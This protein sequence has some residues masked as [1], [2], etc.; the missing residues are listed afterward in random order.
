MKSE[1]SVQEQIRLV[2]GQHDHVCDRNNNGALPDKNGRYVRYGLGNDS[3]SINEV[4]KSSDLIG[5]VSMLILP[6]HVGRT[7]GVY[8]AT[9]VKKEGWVWE[10]NDR[11]LAQLAFINDIT[12]HGGIGMFAASVDDY[13]KRIQEFTK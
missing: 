2:A 13:L 6:H 8:C 4:R 10:G 3:P 5:C 12:R 9:E 1:A 11:E 7:I